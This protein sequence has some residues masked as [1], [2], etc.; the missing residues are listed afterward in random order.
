MPRTPYDHDDLYIHRGGH[1][2]EVLKEALE[3]GLFSVYFD[4]ISKS[5]KINFRSS[6]YL[7]ES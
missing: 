2:D 1:L 3:L 6:E 4:E 7:D 5:L